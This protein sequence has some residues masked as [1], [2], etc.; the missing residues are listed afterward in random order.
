[1][2]RFRPAVEQCESRMLPTLV[3]VF[4]GNA[5]AASKPDGPHTQLAASQ[6]MQHGDRAVQLSTPAMESPADFYALV[7]EI[8][9][10]SKGQPIGLMGFS[11]WG[12]WRRGSRASRVSMSKR[13]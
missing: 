12:R 10:I 9:S 7:H 8:R 13:S 6:L 4:N 2:K 3:F 11:A 1:M 5:F